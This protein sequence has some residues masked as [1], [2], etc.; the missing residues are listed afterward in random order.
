[1]WVLYEGEGGIEGP[2]VMTEI[3]E[4]GD[5]SVKELDL[6]ELEFFNVR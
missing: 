1:M 2:Q 6:T 4:R 3:K 5:G